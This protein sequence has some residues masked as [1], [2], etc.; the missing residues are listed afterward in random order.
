MSQRYQHHM[1]CI[2]PNHDMDGKQHY[3]QQ[4]WQNKTSCLIVTARPQ[5][6]F[7]SWMKPVLLEKGGGT[8]S[9]VPLLWDSEGKLL[10]SKSCVLSSNC[11][12][13]SAG[14]EQEYFFVGE[15]I[16][17]RVPVALWSPMHSLLCSYTG[18]FS[19]DKRWNPE[20][21]AALGSQMSETWNERQCLVC[22]PVLSIQ[23]AR[24]SSFPFQE[25]LFM[26][27]FLGTLLGQ[28]V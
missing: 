13:Q 15:G 2:C 11:W 18:E 28:K 25:W 27:F 24:F 6:P 5:T 17:H 16:S 10:K 4:T 22:K 14:V 21:G 19:V 20:R 12:T 8:Q 7:K 26:H 9:P 23:S 3:R 1:Q